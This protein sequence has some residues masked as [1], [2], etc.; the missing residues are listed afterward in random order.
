MSNAG[1]LRVDEVRLAYRIIGE[2]R[3]LGHNPD[4]WFPRMLQ[5]V[6]EL[7][8]ADAAVGGEGRWRSPRGN[9]EAHSVFDTGFDSGSREALAAYHRE[10]RPAGDPIFLA[11]QRMKGQLVTHTRR[12]IIP[13]ATWYR[14][15]CFDYHRSAHVDHQAT[16]VYQFTADNVISV[17]ALHRGIGER[18]FSRHERQLL[19]F[20]HGELGP[21]IGRALVSSNDVTPDMLPRRLRQTLALLLEGQTEKQVAARLQLSPATVHQYV[22]ALYRRFGVRSRAELMAQ[23]IRRLSSG[24]WDDRLYR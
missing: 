7:V 14:S 18:D 17:I 9:I 20:F 3:D 24:A 6:S 16:S 4:L 2:C 22:T 13:D 21:L 19:D 23:A 8:G 15:A 11:M 5:G 12:E 1:R 10:L